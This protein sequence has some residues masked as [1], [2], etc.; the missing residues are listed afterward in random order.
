MAEPAL[1]IGTDRI[2]VAY[3]VARPQEQVNEIEAARSLFQLLVA[4]HRA[5]QLELEQSGEVG[6]RGAREIPERVAQFPVGRL[7]G[8]ACHAI[9]VVPA[10]SRPRLFKLPVEEI[11]QLAFEDVVVARLDF[12]NR[13]D[14]AA[15]PACRLGIAV[16]KIPRRIG[17]SLRQVG[18]VVKLLDQGVDL[19]LARKRLTTPRRRKI[20]PLRQGPAGCSQTAAGA[21]ISG[22]G[23]S[24]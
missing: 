17:A 1:E 16:K 14:L 11:D 15:Q 5:V 23:S 19:R 24:T 8:R 4:L 10:P 13:P 3:E 18:K 21:L 9:A 20:A 22:P 6:I 2:T 7:N 12:F